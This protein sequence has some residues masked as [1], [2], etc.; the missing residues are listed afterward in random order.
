M[1]PTLLALLC[2]GG[3]T[4]FSPSLRPYFAGVGRRSASSACGALG[5]T[6]KSDVDRRSM[7]GTTAA[8]GVGALVGSPE[9][10]KA[11]EDPEIMIMKTTAGDMVGH[12][13]SISRCDVWD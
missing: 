11:A 13:P 6:A 2:I 3:A 7:L 8:A 9:A 4:A 10:A 5:L 1:R 12:S